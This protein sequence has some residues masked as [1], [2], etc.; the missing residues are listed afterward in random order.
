M[1]LKYIKIY[2]TCFFCLFFKWTI[3]HVKLHMWPSYFYWTVLVQLA[4]VGGKQIMILC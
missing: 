3:E 4:R 2:F 1:C